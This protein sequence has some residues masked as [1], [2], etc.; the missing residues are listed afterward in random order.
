MPRTKAERRT[1]PQII[2]EQ[3]TRRYG[4]YKKKQLSNPDFREAYEEGLEELRLG[5]SIAT[6]REQLGLTQTQLAAMLHTSPSV[7]SRVENGENVEL[8][9]LRRIARALDAKLEIELVQ[10]R[11]S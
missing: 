4:E 8:R 10:V 3:Q 1:K 7:I 6:L 5:A 9:T 2:S 11:P